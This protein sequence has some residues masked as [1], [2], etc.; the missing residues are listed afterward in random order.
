MSKLT[1]TF[2]LCYEPSLPTSVILVIKE[3]TNSFRRT[4]SNSCFGLHHNKGGHNFSSRVTSL[5][6]P[7]CGYIS[8][9]G[10]LVCCGGLGWATIRMQV[11]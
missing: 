6:S 8:T 7:L 1:E 5:L 11:S 3:E 4:C 9:N 2:F 10:L